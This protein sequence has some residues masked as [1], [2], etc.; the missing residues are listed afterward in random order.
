M[1]KSWLTS[2]SG[3]TRRKNFCKS[4]RKYRPG[5]VSAIARGSFLV[6]NDKNDLTRIVFFLVIGYK[7]RKC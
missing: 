1:E 3:E 4:L 7:L 5:A 6:K 2:I